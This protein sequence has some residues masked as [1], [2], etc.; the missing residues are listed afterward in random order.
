MARTPA[1]RAP[2]MPPTDRRT[3]ILSAAR[4]VL[5]VR[6]IDDLSVETV[7]AEAGV[8]PG[9]LFHYFGS[10]R[11]FR[12]TVLEAAAQ[13]LLDH[14]RPDPGLSPAA[15]LRAGIETFVDYVTRY[16]TIY[17]AVTRLGGGAG[18]RTLHRSA[19]STLAGWI[20]Q[21]LASAG[22]PV[23]PALT[24][25]VAGWLAYMEEVVLAWLDNP[26]MDRADLLDL[27]ERTAYQVVMVALDDP[28][29]WERIRAGMRAAPDTGV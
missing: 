11:K 26:A 21:G 19:R 2:R 18:V 6:P 10:Q 1:A 20:T 22:A 28:A 13:E 29:E 23:T 3:Q 17:Q 14:V 27:C 5:E 16:P 9:L 7:A 25:S 15:Q 24:F 8:S 4:R 12:H